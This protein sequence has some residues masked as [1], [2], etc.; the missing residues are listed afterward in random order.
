[1]SGV[2]QTAALAQAAVQASGTGATAAGDQ[3]AQNLKTVLEQ[4]TERMKIAADL[5]GAIMNPAG[6]AAGGGGSGG[7]TVSERGAALNEAQ[8]IDT[9]TQET[10]SGV[11]GARA[12]GGSAAAPLSL[13]EE[14]LRRQTGSDVTKAAESVVE[15]AIKPVTPTTPSRGRSKPSGGSAPSGSD[16]PLLGGLQDALKNLADTPVKYTLDITFRLTVNSPS[17]AVT[18]VLV[19]HQEFKTVVELAQATAQGEQQLS[20]SFETKERG[21][22]VAITAFTSTGAPLSERKYVEVPRPTIA[23][24]N[25]PPR[26][27]TIEARPVVKSDTFNIGITGGLVPQPDMADLDVQLLQRGVLSIF[28]IGDPDISWRV[29]GFTAKVRWF[30]GKLAMALRL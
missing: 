19:E 24:P 12:A 20:V 4:H 22:Y 13:Q 9:Q 11:S 23:I 7:G 6:A 30:T 27:F 25:A 8:K 21:V 3:A 26:H 10:G 2:Q 15:N 5:L 16:S 18:K 28:R 14:T 17:L 1:M 29:D